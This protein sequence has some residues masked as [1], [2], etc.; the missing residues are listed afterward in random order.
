[1]VDVTGGVVEVVV[2]LASVVVVTSEVVVVVDG[3]V[4]GGGFAA[5]VPG[6]TRVPPRFATVVLGVADVV[7]A[8][9]ADVVAAGVEVAVDAVGESTG[10]VPLEAE[11]AGAGLGSFELPV[12]TPATTAATTKRPDANMILP[13]TLAGRLC[14]PRLPASCITSDG[15][16]C[17]SSPVPDRGSAASSGSSLTGSPWGAGIGVGP[18]GPASSGWYHFPS[19]A[20]HHPG[21]RDT[22]LMSVPDRR[23]SW[24]F[25]LGTEFRFARRPRGSGT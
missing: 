3:V 17:G 18:S 1:V 20:S 24:L 15:T 5:V 13:L 21:P 9:G 6:E 16:A 12:S 22:S 14:S 11:T 23:S 2:V 7:D 19:V 4:E 25:A 10:A 8:L